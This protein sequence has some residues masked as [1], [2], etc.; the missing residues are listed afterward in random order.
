MPGLHAGANLR[1]PVDGALGDGFGM[2]FDPVLN[3][4]LMHRGQD[5]AGPKGAPIVAVLAG[6]IAEAGRAGSYGNLIIIDHGGGSATAYAKLSHFAPI[7][8]ERNCVAAGDVIGYVGCTGLCAEPHLH[9]EV[10]RGGELVDPAL[11]L[12]PPPAKR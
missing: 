1:P 5:F 7:A 4:R 2:H 6:Q 9:F 12:A 3:Y 10:R 8:R 11:Y